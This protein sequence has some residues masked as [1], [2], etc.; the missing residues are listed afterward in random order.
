MRPGV[1]LLVCGYRDEDR[2]SFGIWGLT[3]RRAGKY[4]G[5]A[6]RYENRL[7]GNR[8]NESRRLFLR[9][10]NLLFLP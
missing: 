4:C 8:W 2:K 6:V 3:V 5:A 7:R 9:N 1:G 10:G